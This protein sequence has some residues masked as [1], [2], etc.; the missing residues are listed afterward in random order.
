MNVKHRWSEGKSRR[1]VGGKKRIMRVEA[2]QTMY[3]YMFK[4]SIMKPTKFCLKK[5]GGGKREWED[6][7]GGGLVQ[8]TLY[9]CM[10]L[11]Q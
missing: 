6:N 10:E 8:S 4:G 5:G 3:M 1:G 9:T 7:G 11:S 2:D